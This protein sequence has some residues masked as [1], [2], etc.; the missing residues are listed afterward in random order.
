MVLRTLVLR[1]LGLLVRRALGLLVRRV[2]GLLVRRLG[3]AGRL[4]RRRGWVVWVLP[5]SLVVGLM[6]C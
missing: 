1:T 6:T 3:R 5:R 4:G 2:P